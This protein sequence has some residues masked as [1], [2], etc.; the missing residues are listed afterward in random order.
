M[1]VATTRQLEQRSASCPVELL[2]ILP[3][4]LPRRDTEVAA[5]RPKD[6]MVDPDVQNADAQVDQYSQLVHDSTAVMLDVQHIAMGCRAGTAQQIPTRGRD[7][8]RAR[9]TQDRHVLHQH[10]PADAEFV[11]KLRPQNRLPRGAKRS[12]QL[13]P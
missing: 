10:L 1:T 3:Y 11:S 13:L 8:I 9:G 7:D 4:I 5:E 12:H 6:G 2:D